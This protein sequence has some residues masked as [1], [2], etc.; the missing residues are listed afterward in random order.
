V[1][2]GLLR[3]WPVVIGVV[4]AVC[5]SNFLLAWALQGFGD[6]ATV[7]SQLEVSGQPDSLLLRTTD[8]LSAVLVLPLLPG[9]RRGLPAGRLRP[10]VVGAAWVFALGALVA[11]TIALPCGPGASCTAPGQVTQRWVHDGSSVVSD[12]AA[13]AAIAGSWWLAHRSGP[14]WLAR[15]SWWVFW[16]G[17]VVAVPVLAVTDLAGPDLLLGLSQRVHIACISIWICCLGLLASRVYADSVH[18]PGSEGE[19]A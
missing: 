12:G 17:G 18:P 5:Y 14:R 4:A 1:T 6:T 3:R 8:V 13:F 19:M 10:L 11:A 2:A 7:V 16:I 9:Y 15:T